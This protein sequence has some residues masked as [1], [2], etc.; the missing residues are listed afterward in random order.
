MPPSSSLPRRNFPK[1]E[2]LLMFLCLIF[3]VT[4]V[5]RDVLA[6]L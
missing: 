1:I 2:V 3:S 6:L 5:L 4:F